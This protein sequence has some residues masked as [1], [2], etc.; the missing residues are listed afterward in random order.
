[1]CQRLQATNV[2]LQ[3]AWPLQVQIADLRLPACAATGQGAAEWAVPPA[4]PFT[5]RIQSVRYHD[6][7]PLAV[8]IHQ[9]A[10]HSGLKTRQHDSH[11]R[12]NYYASENGR[13]RLAGRV[14][15]ARLDTRLAG[16]FTVQGQGQWRPADGDTLQRF[17]GQLDVCVQQLGA[18]GLQARADL[19]LAL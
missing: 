1:D 17:K 8:A 9:R 12:V 11:V 7:A 15:A 14:A 6:Y 19:S 5:V 16:T 10:G 13:W 4:P 2:R 18:P 3:L